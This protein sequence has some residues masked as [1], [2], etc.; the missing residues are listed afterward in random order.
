MRLILEEVP[1]EQET[2]RVGTRAR[3]PPDR[4]ESVFSLLVV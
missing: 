2:M 1:L 3:K 4:Y